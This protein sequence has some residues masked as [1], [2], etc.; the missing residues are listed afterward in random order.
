[1]PRLI[2]SFIAYESQVLSASIK[3]YVEVI[4]LPDLDKISPITSHRGIGLVNDLTKNILELILLASISLQVW[5]CLVIDEDAINI[6][7]IADILAGGAT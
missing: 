6:I 5:F 2:V 7:A 3:G 1:M 4:L